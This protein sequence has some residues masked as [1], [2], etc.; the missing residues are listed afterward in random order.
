M[1]VYKVR[2]KKYIYIHTHKESHTHTQIEVR[3]CRYLPTVYLPHMYIYFQSLSCV[4]L[5]VTPWIEVHQ[6]LLSSSICS[7]ILFSHKKKKRKETLPFTTTYMGLSLSEDIYT[8]MGVQISSKR[9]G[10]FFSFGHIFKIGI[11]GPIFNFLM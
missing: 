4:Q 8:H 6:A 5:F 10:D 11:A 7:G 9:H 3:G 1:C 2:Y